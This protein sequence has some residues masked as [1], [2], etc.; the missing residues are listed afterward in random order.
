MV[1]IGSV[2]RIRRANS[3]EV[4]EYTILGAWDGDPAKNII[5]YRASMAQALLG[6]KENDTVE[7]V[8]DGQHE[9]WQI[10]SIRPY[11]E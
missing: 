5:S 7:A 8:F 3:D 4:T 11:A 9:V 1:S 10:E 6:K 2:V